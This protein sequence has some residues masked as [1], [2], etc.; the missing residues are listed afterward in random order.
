MEGSTKERKVINLDEGKTKEQAQAQARRVAK[1]IAGV[2]SKKAVI[3]N[4]H[5]M[6][7]GGVATEVEHRTF[8]DSEIERRDI[9]YDQ[10][11]DR[12]YEDTYEA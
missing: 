6:E 9:K 8:T 11:V 5:N 12:N 10:L 1:I 3:M 7:L 4:S 2:A